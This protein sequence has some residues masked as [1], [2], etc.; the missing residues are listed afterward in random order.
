MKTTDELKTEILEA[1]GN[2]KELFIEYI[3]RTEGNPQVKAMW[4]QRRENQRFEVKSRNTDPFI[5]KGWD[6]LVSFTGRK[7]N[8]LKQYL[9][10]GKGKIELKIYKDGYD[11]P[12]LYTIVKL[13]D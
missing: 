9:V 1:L 5:I 13:K 6:E 7:L 12:E 4:K 2:K 3:S 8:T 10:Q 11:Y